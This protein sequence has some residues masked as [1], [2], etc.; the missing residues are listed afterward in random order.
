MK[1]LLNL[2][3]L[4]LFQLKSYVPLG[5]ALFVQQ[6]GKKYRL[7]FDKRRLHKNPSKLSFLFQKTHMVQH[8][9]QCRQHLM[10]HPLKN[11]NFNDK[12]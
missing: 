5:K 2:D 12:F 11:I 9:Y 6:N 4:A 1:L 10:I 7:Q 8:K 3:S